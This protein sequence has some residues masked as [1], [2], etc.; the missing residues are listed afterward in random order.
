MSYTELYFKI[1]VIGGIVI[2]SIVGIV[3]I[4]FI[5][6]AIIETIREKIRKYK[7]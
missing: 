3:I 7:K 1:Q 2:G 6:Y 5:V 4:G